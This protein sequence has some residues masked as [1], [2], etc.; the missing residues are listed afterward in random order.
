MNQGLLKWA[1]YCR[2]STDD[3]ETNGM[4]LPY[5][6]DSC[7]KYAEKNNLN[8]LEENIFLE[9]FSWWFLERPML[10]YL[11]LIAKKGLINFVIFTKRD[12]VAR[13]Q[14]VFQKIIKD[15]TEANVKIFY[16]EEKLT[17][18]E[19]MDRFIGSSIINFASWER[20]QIKLRTNSWKRQFAKENK[21][22]FWHT[23]YWY[24]RNPE[25][26]KLE[27]FEEEKGI[28]LKI[29]DK[30]LKDKMTL[31]EVAK[32]LTEN[33]ILPPSMSNKKSAHQTINIAKKKSPVFHWSATTV[34]R[35]LSKASI[36]TWVYQWFSKQHK[37]TWSWFIVTDRPKEDW[38]SIEIP[39]IISDKE[40]ELILETLENNRKFAKKRAVRTYMLQW[41]LYCDCES[42]LH[43]FTWYYHN[44]K[45][46]KNYRCSLNNGSKVSE[47]RRCKNQ[48][49]W[50]KI[51]WVVIDTL[52]ELFTEP[53]YLITR[54]LE[55][56]W[57]RSDM[58]TSEKVAE[59]YLELEQLDTKHKRNQELFIEWIIDKARFNEIKNQLDDKEKRIRDTFDK[60]L[61]IL[62]SEEFR[63]GAKENLTDIINNLKEEIEI[64]FDKASYDEL[65]ELV[66]LVV[67]KII[68]SDWKKS[69]TARIIMKIPS[70]NL[71]FALR[72]YEEES[73]THI[74]DFW[75][76]S[77][78]SW[79]WEYIPKKLKVDKFK[80]PIEYRTVEFTSESSEDDKNI[81]YNPFLNFIKNMYHQY[82][83]DDHDMYCNF[84]SVNLL[85]K[86]KKTKRPY[87]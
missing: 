86:I 65:K 11:L 23:P 74:D 69:K 70:D 64:F 41:K 80:S 9:Q 58:D 59:L 60:E 21:W 47:D 51:E 1:I 49:S 34:Q 18:N 87:L 22:P 3:Q 26:K 15:L 72:Y 52:R 42:C 17:W 16:S 32:Y 62:K 8:V 53:E 71:W 83:K 14:Y 10:N 5:Q 66:W 40:A 29:V 7:L 82:Y 44:A 81:T 27:I 54:A 50:L 63:N 46:L 57:W 35:I 12:R 56:T 25:T 45:G 61:E 38:I 33:K 55:K 2:V 76:E 84:F 28:L 37:K 79:T 48:I 20:E 75:N 77:K 13:D 67:D 30:Y 31:W 78:I 36:Y 6:K 19:A 68:L 85:K 73:V 24:I 43:S 4:S 39:R